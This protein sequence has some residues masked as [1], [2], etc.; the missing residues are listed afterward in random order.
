MIGWARST[1]EHMRPFATGGVYLDVAGLDDETE[2]DEVYGG[3]PE[4]G[5]PPSLLQ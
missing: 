5:D 1:W 4:R 3:G 2:P